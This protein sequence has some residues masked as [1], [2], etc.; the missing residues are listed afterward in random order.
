MRTYYSEFEGDEILVTEDDPVLRAGD[1]IIFSFS[2]IG[3]PHF[4]QK[5]NVVSK[6][7]MVTKSDS[8]IKTFITYELK[9]ETD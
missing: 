9:K 6:K 5:Y 2:D 7:A 8:Y 4:Y 1:E 3:A